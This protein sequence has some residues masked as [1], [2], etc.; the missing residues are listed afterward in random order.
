MLYQLNLTS[1]DYNQV[2]GG[3]RGEHTTTAPL[4]DSFYKPELKIP[5]LDRGVEWHVTSLLQHM[6]TARWM[7][8]V[9]KAA[10]V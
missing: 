9:L 7:H 8:L 2:E 1:N 4:R 3:I 5:V 6:L 10:Q